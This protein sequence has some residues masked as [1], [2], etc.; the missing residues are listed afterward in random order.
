MSLYYETLY[1]WKCKG[2]HHKLAMDA[3]QLLSVEDA[4]DWCD[5]FLRY[6]ESYLTGTKDPDTKF[7]DFR[8]HVLHTSDNYWGGAVQATWEWYGKTRQAF[9]DGQWKQGVYSAGVMSHY[10]TD[11]FCPLHTGQSA[12]ENIIH[13]ACEWSISCSYDDLLDLLQEDLGGFPDIKYPPGDDWL[14]QLIRAEATHAHFLY[15]SLV[16]GY[17]FD[18]GI[19]NPAEGLDES[20]TREMALTLG[21][22]CASLAIVL[23][24][25]LKESGQKPPTVSLSLHALLGQLTIPVFWVTRKM[26]DVS[27]R[28]EV[29]RIYEELRRTGTVEKYLPEEN[30][31]LRDLL[32]QEQT[33]SGS[34][35][36]PAVQPTSPREKP[37]IV[38]ST[39]P[40]P[41]STPATLDPFE[42][43]SG[44]WGIRPVNVPEQQ[45]EPP[46]F[47]DESSL[48]D[49]E[50]STDPP[51]GTRY[52]L[53]LDSPI[54][55]A[56]SIGPKTASRFRKINIHKVRELL[57]SEP[58]HLSQKLN[59]RWI[60]PDMVQNWQ[61][62]AELMC[63]VPALRC[64]DAQI[65]QGVGVANRQDLAQA[66]P[67]DL[68]S[69]VNEFCL[70]SEGQAILRSGKMPD[71][72]EVQ[73]W[74]ENARQSQQNQA[75]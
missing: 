4:D 30:R 32:Q 10:L 61:Q 66:R 47:E 9:A 21:R 6:I 3:L 60:T 39:K 68:L 18:K 31:V 65:L 15:F 42:E 43:E 2:T 74:I 69:L 13:R 5:L 46:D 12:R 20:L 64:H 72:N 19:K 41:P 1:A 57:D 62:Q 27:A 49:T 8:N 7:K 48:Y 37:R 24:R 56:P 29:A 45:L 55:D 70:T 14:S 23:D 58:R 71:L 35:D 59:A 75:A 63:T 17:N 11:I 51:N 50:S 25:C 44:H 34:A 52:Y 16:D 67:E 28:R 53:K 73:F 38:V 54:V 40:A 33:V 26:A 22:A 36:T